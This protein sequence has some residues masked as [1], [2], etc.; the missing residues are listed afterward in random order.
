MVTLL[1]TGILVAQ[2]CSGPFCGPDDVFERPMAGLIGSAAAPVAVL[3]DDGAFLLAWEMRADGEADIAFNRREPGA[4]GR[5]G[6]L[7]V[8]IDTDEWGAARSLEPRLAAGPGGLVRVVWQDHRSGVDDLRIRASTDG[9]RSW[10]A[11]DRRIGG[12]QDG[13]L[14]SLA[15]LAAP[16]G[17]RLIVAWED[18]RS[19]RRDLWMVRSSDGGTTWEPEGR[20]DSDAPGTGVSYHPQLAAWEDG[21]LL[22]AWW[23]ERDGRADV[24]VRRSADG[25]VTWTGPERRLDPGRP[26]E[27]NS[28][29]VVVS[30]AGDTVSLL[31]EEEH[32]GIGGNVVSRTSTDRGATWGPLEVSGSGAHPVGVARDGM[33]PVVAWSRPP[34]HRSGQKTSI[35]G[36]IVEIP[37]PTEFSVAAAGASATPLLAL[38]RV[39]S[40]WAGSGGWR[41]FVARAGTA[42]GRA[43]VDVSSLNTELPRPGPVRVALMNFG[44]EF[45]GTALDVVADSV[46]G[47]ADADGTLHLVWVN[48]W[49]DEG[50]LAYRRLHP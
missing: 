50:D 32:P 4:D 38:E 15:A 14:R 24:Y 18:L 42:S 41:A 21:T 47:A 2:S 5:W 12:G 34:A 19:G 3:A 26:G 33:L 22:V 39:T 40:T 44:G 16:G 25:G 23:D 48:R 7:P 49:G 27:S 45:L 46:T 30:R 1:A 20:I 29:A 35:G 36:R 10:E 37:L 9:G 17:E 13:A 8:R 28:H 6:E 31:W 11:S 43:V